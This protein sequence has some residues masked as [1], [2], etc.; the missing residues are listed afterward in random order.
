MKTPDFLREKKYFL[1]DRQ[2]P[3]F[4]WALIVWGTIVILFVSII[5]HTLFL[6]NVENIMVSDKAVGVS[7]P[8]TIDNVRLKSILDAHNSGIASVSSEKAAALA[9]P[10]PS[11]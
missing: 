5:F 3:L 9:S 7:A 10:D 4:A 2:Y 1:P 11:K 6:F 8:D